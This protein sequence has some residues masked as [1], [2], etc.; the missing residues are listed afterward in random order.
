M[1]NQSIAIVQRIR[2]YFTALRDDGLSYGD[3]IEQLTYLLFLKM[4][5]ERRK[6]G[7]SDDIKPRQ[8]VITVTEKAITTNLA[9]A[10]R[11][12]QSILGHA[13]TGQLVPQQEGAI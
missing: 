2:D 3:Y 6:I 12:R 5:N 8:F 1:S 9:R 7:V 4:N 10:E 13:F 11:L